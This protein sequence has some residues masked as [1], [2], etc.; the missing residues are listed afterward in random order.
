MPKKPRGQNRHRRNRS[1]KKTPFRPGSQQLRNADNF[2]DNSASPS[3]IADMM[4]QGEEAKSGQFAE[5][6]GNTA[7]PVKRERLHKL[8]AQS[9]HGSRR[10]ME[11]LIAGGRVMING[12]V[13]TAGAHVSP[14][15]KVLI[16]HRL[17]PIKFTPDVPR[18]LLYHKPEGE[19]VSNAD[20]G[21]RISVFD[22]LPKVENGKWI[23]IGRLDFNT[24]GLLIFTTSGDL[25]NKMMHPRFEVEREYA[26]RILGELTDEQQQRLLDGIDIDSAPGDEDEDEEL[27]FEDEDG[28]PIAREHRPARFT[29]IEKRAGPD[30]E[31]S[32]ANNWYHVVI[33]EG[34]NREVRRMFEALG[35]TVSRLMRVRFGKV[36]LPPQLRRG[37]LQELDPAQVKDLLIWAGVSIEGMDF[38]APRPQQK[39]GRRGAKAGPRPLKGPKRDPRDA[40]QARPPRGQQQGQLQGAQQGPQ[41]VGVPGDGVPGSSGAANPLGTGKPGRRKP[42]GRKGQRPAQPQAQPAGANAKP[43]GRRN[44]KPGQAGPQQGVPG[45][46]KA[47]GNRRGNKKA[48]KGRTMEVREPRSLR[49]EP[50]VAWTGQP[51]TGSGRRGEGKA[52]RQPRIIRTVT[53]RPRLPETEGES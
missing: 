47:A 23:A 8:L 10:D 30:P 26:V 42:R 53:R 14:G 48:R 25:A 34:R 1:G 49:A 7:K 45:Q 29:F 31:K 39:A 20:P 40:R 43:R 19:I 33:K 37:A 38:N 22:N 50:M 3:L 32:S 11:I 9:G 36:E 18:V 44:R 16:D 41:D 12:N 5:A 27:L 24:S 35:L 6:L 13:A 46:A 17:V 4:R 28:E 15:D 2:G 51:I 21:N 52:A